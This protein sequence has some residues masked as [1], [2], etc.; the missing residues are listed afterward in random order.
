M[1]CKECDRP[2]KKCESTLRYHT[3]ECKGYEHLNGHFEKQKDFQANTRMD[4]H[5]AI[6]D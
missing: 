1:K 2:I 5:I 4:M 3:T 6:G